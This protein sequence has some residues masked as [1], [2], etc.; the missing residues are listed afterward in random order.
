MNVW[1]RIFAAGYDRVMAST[2]QAGLAKRRRDLLA[3]VHGAVVE[4]GAGTG[5]NLAAYPLGALTELVLVEPEEPM[6]KRL[7]QR[8]RGVVAPARV[9][10]APA[11]SIPLPDASFDFAVCTL[12]LCTV[13]DPA[14]AL[15]EL[16]RLLKPGG[17]L[18][19][20]EHVRAEDPGLARWQDRLAPVWLRVGHGCHCNRSTLAAIQAGGFEVT[21]VEQ[22]RMPKAFPIL[23]PLIVGVATR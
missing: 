5:A 16:R 1:G 10:R 12:V 18:L 13:S 20:L 6:A 4:I 17:Q 19:F 14:Q 11:E 3:R 22:G 21:D 7:E 15:A 8:L 23:K 2:E 9:L